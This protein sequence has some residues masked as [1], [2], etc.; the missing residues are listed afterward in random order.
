MS[1]GIIALLA[2]LQG[3]TE[4]LPVSSSG[5]LALAQVML[6]LQNPEENLMVVVAL[7]VG[8]LL[9]ILVY[10]YRDFLLLFTE[11]RRE[12][13]QL[14]VASIPAGVV[15]FLFLDQIEALFQSLSTICLLLMVNGI[16]LWMA[17]HFAGKSGS[18][19]WWEILG[20]GCAQV[21]GMVPGISRSGST[22]G[23]G[24]L[25]G[26]RPKDAVRFSFLLG[27][28]AIGGAGMLQ[29]RKAL[30]GQVE[31]EWLPI[32]LGVAV[33]FAVSLAAIR[34]VTL[35]AERKRLRWFAGYCIGL[36]LVV[37]VLA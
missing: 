13:W 37:F 10:F 24:L 19:G 17:E 14:T 36:G 31:L 32:L 16:F 26:V 23:T 11:R 5:H 18:L 6:G 35:L 7:H 15:G 28:I 20:I 25:L 21:A 3:L 8:S 30:S 29:A 22:I 34:I 2:L 1:I 9:A 4:F 33:S 12:M 27:A